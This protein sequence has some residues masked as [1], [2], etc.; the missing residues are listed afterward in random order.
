MVEYTD[1][2]EHTRMPCMGARVKAGI[3]CMYRPEFVT[4]YIQ[5][6]IQVCL[7]PLL[8]LHNAAVSHVNWLLTGSS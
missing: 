7:M 5:A 8:I 2:H 3:R 6:F 4:V 1:D